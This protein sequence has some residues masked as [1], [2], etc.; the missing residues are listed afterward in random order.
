MAVLPSQ[1]M[2]IGEKDGRSIVVFAVCCKPPH[3]VVKRLDNACRWL[4]HCSHLIIHP[5]VSG[6]AQRVAR[7]LCFSYDMI[8][9]DSK[10]ASM[11]EAPV[12][13]DP[14]DFGS[15]LKRFASRLPKPGDLVKGKIISIDNGAV[16][17]DIDGIATGVV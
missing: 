3:R 5:T 12:D 14:N 16:R 6:L 11:S 13:A 7:G 9:E 15:L 10:E 1:E 8:N 17:L 4:V 2:C